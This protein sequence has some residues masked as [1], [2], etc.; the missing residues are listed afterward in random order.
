VNHSDFDQLREI[1]G[2]FPPLFT[3]GGVSQLATAKHPAVLKLIGATD[4]SAFV[5]ITEWM[6]NS[7][8]F[9]ISAIPTG[10]M[11]PGGR[12]IAAFDIACRMQFLHSCH[13][14]HRDLK[15]SNV[16]LDARYRIRICDFGFSRFAS[17]DNPKTQCWDRNAHVRPMRLS[18]SLC[19]KKSYFQGR[20]PERLFEVHSGACDDRRAAVARGRACDQADRRR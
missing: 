1:G 14:V 18:S 4:T 8:L 12:V 2:A 5:I 9:M 11:R 7:S 15:S 10:W 20:E 3:P 19:L 6:P 16:L 13:I 17:E